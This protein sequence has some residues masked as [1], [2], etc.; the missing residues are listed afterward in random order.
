MF[1]KEFKKKEENTIEIHH[2]RSSKQQPL[3][4]IYFF[5]QNI[6]KNGVA[7]LQLRFL[8]DKLD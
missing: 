6:H 5:F 7:G 8:F 3:E 1:L 4:E 2:F